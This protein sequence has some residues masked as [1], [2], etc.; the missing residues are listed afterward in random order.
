MKAIL[1]KLIVPLLI[2]GAGVAGA[3]VLKSKA[4]KAKH[5]E[6][7]QRVLQVETNIVATENL[8]VKVVASGSVRAAK[9]IT[10]SPEVS[11]RITYVSPNLIPGS[12]FSKGE[13][14]ARIDKRDY[15]LA[16]E[17]QE[18]QVAQAKLNLTLEH[19][20][21][22]VA[23]EEWA[24][25][26]EKK[27]GNSKG[28]LALRKPQ[29]REAKQQEATAQS[30]LA[31]AALNLK[32]TV[33]KAPFDALVI[34]KNVD[35]GQVVGPSSQLVSLMGTSELWVDVSVPVE[36]LASIRIPGI[37]SDEGSD[38]KVV[39]KVGGDK[40]IVRNGKVIRLHGQLDNRNRTAT[41]LVSIPRPFEVGQAE[42]PLLAGAFVEVEIQGEVHQNII[43]I[44]RGAHREGR[45]VWRVTKDDKLKRTEV[46][47][48]WKEPNHVIVTKGLKSGDEIVVS[49]VAFP[50][51]GMPV[52]RVN[53]NQT[54]TPVKKSAAADSAP[55]G[56]VK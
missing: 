29:L 45:Y 48:G 12:R 51:E 54:A 50:L 23:K 55:E 11:G 15:K 34:E 14:I 19:S 28:S 46:E 2:V 42:L 33:I 35:F 17:Q 10:L 26:G 31:R 27:T 47:I 22:Q 5:V 18:G 56:T 38:A 4:Q 24:L 40:T 16:L 49:P 44:P 32:K 1:F 13:L 41:L 7:Q 25:I 3:M 52:Q 9:Q 20:R 37:N 6:P 39:Q 8:P 53:R 21:G 43:R 36:Q 30:G